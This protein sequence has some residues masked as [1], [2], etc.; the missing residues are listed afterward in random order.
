MRPSEPEQGIEATP[1]SKGLRLQLAPLEKAFRYLSQFPN[2]YLTYLSI[3]AIGS[4]DP[5]LFVSKDAMQHWF[6]EFFLVCSTVP[7]LMR[8][9]GTFKTGTNLSWVI[10]HIYEVTSIFHS[11]LSCVKV[12]FLILMYVLLVQLSLTFKKVKFLQILPLLLSFNKKRKQW[13]SVFQHQP[14]GMVW[15][16]RYQQEFKSTNQI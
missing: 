7:K 16:I 3:G 2:V 5:D 13:N 10:N 6:H 12:I 11:S 14:L 8:T 15:P 1:H 4:D 9:S